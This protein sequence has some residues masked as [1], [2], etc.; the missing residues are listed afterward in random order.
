MKYKTL[1]LSAL[2]VSGLALQST[3]DAASPAVRE[4]AGILSHLN[5]YPSDSEKRSLANI[6]KD[7]NA[8][9]AERVIA[10]AMMHMRHHVSS[11]D[12]K[13]L[14]AIA[15]DHRVDGDARR[16]ARILA[17][18]NHHPGSGDVEVLRDIMK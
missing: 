12:R 8:N 1:A 14:D 13:H 18:V 11:P 4:M 6:V 10:E 15:E 3:A 5:H 17:S 7:A 2:L 16:L 9:R